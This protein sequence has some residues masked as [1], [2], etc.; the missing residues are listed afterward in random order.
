MFFFKD[1]TQIPAEPKTRIPFSPLRPAALHAVKPGCRST[2]SNG[3]IQIFGLRER[4]CPA[5]LVRMFSAV[6]ARWNAP[7]GY[8]E[9]L[10]VGMPL[11]AGM[12]SSTAMQFTDRLFL[13][14]YS[15]TAIAAAMPSS[16]AAMALQLPL[17]GL[18]GYVS[19]FIA[20]YVGA[21]RHKEVGRALW[22]GVWLALA[23][24]VLL[25]LSCLLAVPLFTWTGHPP[26]VIA[27]E[28]IY[29]RI[30][31]LGS[32][33]FLFGAV[34]SGFFI[35]RGYTRPVLFA[36][37]AAAML[38]IPLD[39][40]LIF[41]KWGLPELGIAGAG[42][43]TVIGWAFCTIALGFG[44]FTKKNNDTFRVF[45]AWKLKA[46]VFVRL[47]RFGIPSGVNLFMEV[48]GFAWFVLEVGK[49]GEVA[50]AASNIAF[51]V[52]SLAFMPMLGLNTAVSSLVGQ[53]MGRKQPK[54]A[55]KAT[56]SALHLSLAYMLPLCVLF[57]VFAGQLMDVFQPA[58]AATNYAPIRDTGIVLIW[59]I[60]IYS[61]VD[62]GNIVYLGALKGAGDTFFVMLILGGTGVL[63]LFI[64]V[65]TLKFLGIATLHRLW[66]VLTAYVVIMAVCAYLRF[67]KR[68][69]QKMRVVD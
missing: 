41:G 28:I 9:V 23:G 13:S 51:S 27:D 69:W 46:D 40:A 67:Q 7:Q 37:F 60:A 4:A 32:A 3:E 38:N 43:A 53:A 1:A 57:V 8:R 54:E 52:N 49:L 30:L 17:V 35:G 48:V 6:R 14:H 56:Q 21:G 58:G 45:Q 22:Q 15:V 16:M 31:T 59:Y 10:R 68:K 19:V 42:F 29:F 44:V 61:L 62:S 39:Y 12:L 66:T 18:C 5:R 34:V 65:M 20:H 63:A 36:N 47:L 24:S 11:I 50:L 2:Q 26:A 55:E 64:P 33:F 25:G